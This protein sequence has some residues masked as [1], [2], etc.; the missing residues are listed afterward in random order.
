[1][2]DNNYYFKSE[3][4]DKLLKK[5][6]GRGT[7]GRVIRIN[8]KT[9]IKLYHSAYEKI[10]RRL[11][12]QR[13]VDKIGTNPE[14]DIRIYEIGKTKLPKRDNPDYTKYYQKEDGDSFIR[15]SHKNGIE[16]AIA[17][18]KEIKRTS[19]PAGK[20]YID[21]VLSGCSLIPQRGV[22]I[23]YL[24]FILPTRIRSKILLDVLES[25]KELTDHFIYPKDLEN[26][27]FT[28]KETYKEKTVGH[29]HVLVNPITFETHIIDLDGKSTIY[30]N[31]KSTKYESKSY[32]SFKKLM[33]E[34]LFGRNLDEEELEY[35]EIESI[36]HN[37]D[38]P[39]EYIHKLI[40]DTMNYEDLYSLL[41]YYAKERVRNK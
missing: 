21:G 38:V 40:N 6:I 23:H 35:Q 39:E 7:D 2:S 30:T 26:S 4:L 9:L 22:P 16:K 18:Q 31:F 28:S 33:D 34:F 5:E 37:F 41:S 12:I 8:N 14:E 11:L 15:L 29:S 25:V 19:L 36:Y 17:K 3:D 32:T 24:G 1:M 13:E 27:P 10:R 20:V